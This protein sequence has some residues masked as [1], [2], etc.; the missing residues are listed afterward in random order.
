MV[1]LIWGPPDIPNAQEGWGQID[2]ERTVLP[3]DGTTPLNTFIDHNKQLKA[4]FGLLY[5]FSLDSSHGI[6][7]TLAWSDEEGSANAAQ[8][9]SRLVNDLDLILIDPSGNEWLGNDFASGFSTTGGTCRFNQQ[10]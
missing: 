3:M 8:S 9:T 4:G 6:D 10:R 5:S 2:L 7:I 1:Q